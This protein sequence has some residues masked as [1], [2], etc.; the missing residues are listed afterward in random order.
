M[1]QSVLYPGP[2]K[3]GN[4]CD[5]VP[6]NPRLPYRLNRMRQ[7]SARSRL[8]LLEM[9]YR[10]GSGHVGSSLS[11]V[12]LITV[13]RFGHMNWAAHRP[14]LDADVFVLSKGH[15]VPAWY[16][17][18]VVSGELPAHE[19]A[20]LRRIGSR[21]QGH[22]DRSR[23]DLVDVST[24]ALGQ[25]LSVAVG[26]AEAKRLKQ[27]GSTVYC[28][29]GDGEM[30]EGQVWEALMYA[31]VRGVSNLVVIIDHNRSQSDGSTADIMPLDPLGEKLRAFH[32][33][34]QEIDGHSHSDI[35]DSI[36]NAKASRQH[37]SIIIANTRKGYIGKG[38]I[39]LNGSH[40][41]VLGAEEYAQ[42]VRYLQWI[43]V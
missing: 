5:R 11:C 3:S 27:Q 43:A 17:T 34:V 33:H 41:T 10:A 1:G 36:I 21:L 16:A 24:G 20:T 19:V 28:I 26:R 2:A 18:L 15:A 13:L 22:P 30:Q 12:D 9:I 29:I 42:A 4:E 6:E 14:R 25:G 39:L 31:G 8:I 37:P 40:S 23:L 35:H 38:R 32:W 7:L